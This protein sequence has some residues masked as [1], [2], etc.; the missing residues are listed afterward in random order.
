MTLD[1][2]I[3]HAELVANNC[4]SECSDEHR[5]LAEWLRELQELKTENDALNGFLSD[6]AERCGTHECPS[7]IA[8]V[9]KLKELC[10]SMW[11]AIPK[12][13]SCEW[14]S[15]ANCCTGD[16]NGECGYWYR[17]RELGIEAD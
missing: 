9:N 6:V 8:Y 12:S 3:E 7:L 17:M 16:C 11:K 4:E 15:E 10:A 5:Q 14:D 1:E 13:E 2:A